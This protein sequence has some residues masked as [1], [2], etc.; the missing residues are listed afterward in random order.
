MKDAAPAA[1]GYAI[2]LGIVAVLVPARVGWELLKRGQGELRVDVAAGEMYVMHRTGDYFR[3]ID[4][5]EEWGRIT[6]GEI[7]SWEVEDDDERF[8][9]KENAFLWAVRTDESRMCIVRSYPRWLLEELAEDLGELIGNAKE[10]PRNE[11]L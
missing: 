5:K 9:P 8:V 6:L 10:Q 1:V 3:P 4:K 11:D 7:A 2:G